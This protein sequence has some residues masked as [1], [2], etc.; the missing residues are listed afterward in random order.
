MFGDLNRGLGGIMRSSMRWGSNSTFKAS[1]L[2]YPQMF[3]APRA[4]T[5]KFKCLVILNLAL[6]EIMRSPTRWG[7]NFTFKASNSKHPQI[8]LFFVTNLLNLNV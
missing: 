8:I 7:S 3:F 1:N 6:G 4:K 5:A 2:K